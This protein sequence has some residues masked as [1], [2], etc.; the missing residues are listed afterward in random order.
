MPISF[1]CK[2]ENKQSKI[3][4][5]D[6]LQCFLTEFLTSIGVDPEIAEKDAC[7]IE[8]DLSNESYE[9]LKRFKQLHEQSNWKAG[10]TDEAS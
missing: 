8:H 9:R 7:K 1:F 6:H 4:S 10:K 3:L 2:K 5:K